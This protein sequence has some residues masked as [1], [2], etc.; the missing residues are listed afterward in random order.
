MTVFQKT[1]MEFVDLGLSVKWAAC[2]IGAS[3][4]E[5]CGV[6]VAQSECENLGV[7]SEVRVPSRKEFLELMRECTWKFTIQNGVKGN[8]VVGPNGNSIFLPSSFDEGK[9]GRYWS[10]TADEN[11]AEQ[12]AYCLDFDFIGCRMNSECRSG[13]LCMRTVML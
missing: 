8:L 12:C 2:N 10:S 3:S 9:Q 13:K 11:D 6:C 5:D 4:P 7:G 1:K